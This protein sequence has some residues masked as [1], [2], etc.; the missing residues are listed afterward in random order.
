MTDEERARRKERYADYKL[1][2]AALMICYPFTLEDLDG[3]IWKWISGYEDIYQISTYS[4][5]KSFQKGKVKIVK[6]CLHTCGYLYV[7]LFKNGKCKKSKL[8]RLVAEAFIPNPDDK[9]GVD[10]IFNN[11]FDNY[12]ENLRWATQS[13]N[14]QYA[15]NTGAKKSGEES[16][17][18]MLTNE[19]VLW[20]R[21]HYKVRD[22]EFGATALA[23]K[24]NV[25]AELIW[26]AAIG[27]T[28]KHV[29]NKTEGDDTHD[30]K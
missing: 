14:N 28:Y 3:E 12:F 29:G 20:I 17:Q 16:Y 19:Q 13:E 8:H 18:A 6:P 25:N 21:E 27:K 26:N 11:K 9:K 1:A 22:K 23:E 7:D 5:V 30:D 10:H 4:R 15:Y 24:F 2:Y